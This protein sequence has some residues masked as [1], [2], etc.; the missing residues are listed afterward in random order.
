MPLLAGLVLLSGCTATRPAGPAPAPLRTN[1]NLH[2]VLWVQTALEYEAS[3]L[4]AYRAAARLLDS[5]LVDP[6][7]TA[8]PEQAA[9]GAYEALP[10]A[11]VLDVD[12]TVLDN[13]AYQARLIEDE[14]EYGRAS[15]TAWVEEAAATPVPGAL[16]FTRYAAARGVR[17]VYLT[18]RRAGEEAATRRNLA[19]LGFP[20]AEADDVVITRGERPAWE[21]SDKG[22]RRAAV[23]ARYRILLLVGDNLGD[24]LSDVDTTLAARAA[25]AQPYQAYWGR[26]WIMLPNPQYGSW[27]GALFDQDYGLPR[28]E[29][30]RR[31]YERLRTGR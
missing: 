3:A 9:A 26:Q 7:W 24:F 30:L 16:D 19:R 6:G 31:K 22:P 14:A 12:E 21:A 20:L 5:A 13:S 11:V 18:N 4:Q 25:L 2:A 28:S 1:E 17:V 10:P 27:E 29:K 23:A 15:W 8:A